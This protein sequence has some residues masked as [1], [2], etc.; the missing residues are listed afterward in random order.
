MLTLRPFTV[1][2]AVAN[3][4]A[5]LAARDGK[6]QPVGHV[7]QT[8]LQLLDEQ[9]AGD[10]AGA[11]GL[12]VVLA[13]LAFER[14]VHALGLLLLVQLQAV[15]HDLGLAIFAVLAG[16]KVALLDRA[17]VGECTWCPS[18]KAWCLRDGKGG[19]LL[20]YN[21]PFLLLTSDDGRFTVCDF[22]PAELRPGPI[23]FSV[24]A[25]V[26]QMIWLSQHNFCKLPCKTGL[27]S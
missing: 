18:K 3:D 8:A 15:A 26:A 17:T 12:L 11:V 5:G 14:E 23:Q 4:L 10:A 22:D 16:R 1:N 9:F 21:V 6:A 25:S 20:R 13:E 19:R 2:V 24:T 7:V 27:I